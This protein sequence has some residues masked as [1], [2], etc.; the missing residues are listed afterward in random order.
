MLNLAFANL[1]TDW[2]LIGLG[3]KPKALS[4]ENVLS[5]ANIL[6]LLLM[7]NKKLFFFIICNIFYFQSLIGIK[8]YYDIKYHK[9]QIFNIVSPVNFQ[10]VIMCKYS[11]K[12]YLFPFIFPIEQHASIGHHIDRVIFFNILQ[13]ISS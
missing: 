3:G 4:K 13:H 9:Q 8:K 12:L 11:G 10:Y 7:Q 2:Q 5:R 6:Q 1:S